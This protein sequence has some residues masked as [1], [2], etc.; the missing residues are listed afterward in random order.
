[1]IHF[2]QTRIQ[3]QKIQEENHTNCVTNNLDKNSLNV[4]EKYKLVCWVFKSSKVI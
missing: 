1:M 2:Q 3:A 4:L